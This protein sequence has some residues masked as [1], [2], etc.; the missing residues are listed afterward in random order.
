MDHGGVVA[1]MPAV[2]DSDRVILHVDMDAFFAAIAEQDDPSLRDHPVLIGS[3]SPRAVV[4]TA[5]YH[6]RRYGCHSAM[7]MST[8]LRRCPHARVVQVSRQRIE[9]FS[10]RVLELFHEVTPL[11]EPL[12]LD[13]AFLDVTGSRRLLGGAE[14]IARQ[15]KE[16]IVAE[17][18]LTASVGVAPNRFLAKLASEMDKPDG[19][20][21]IRSEQVHALL[22]PLPVR[23]IPGVGPTAEKRLA[24]M[25]LHRVGQLRRQGPVALRGLLGE[26]GP[27]LYEL[28]CG[29]DP[30]PVVPD[31][32]ARSMGQ[33]QTFGQDLT[34][35]QQIRSVLLGQAEQIAARLRRRGV[36]AQALTLKIRFGDFQTV[37]RRRS[38][39]QPIQ[40][41]RSLWRAADEL[42]AEW[43]ERS[44]HPVRLIGLNA[45][46]LRHQPERVSG[47]GELFSD[48]VQQKHQRL[49]AALDVLADRFGRGVVR[50]AAA[51]GA[52]RQP[53]R[54]HG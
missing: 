21:V 51:A 1:R 53:P 17:T 13:E 4:A 20:T 40:S 50:R 49:E 12:S 18:G 26:S 24:R 42:L 30:R 33:E 29:L 9:S 5:N 14:Q 23:R 32:V 54:E 11:V 2:A 7:P 48:P 34:N 27:A 46:P 35:L 3:R 38:F 16:R 28:A 47:Q 15:L 52:L 25:G 39:S 45:G 10:R 37:T 22:D 8:A 19:L 41:T 31:P 6:A 43:A 36:Y 44:F